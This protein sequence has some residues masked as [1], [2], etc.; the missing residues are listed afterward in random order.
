MILQNNAYVFQFNKI[1]S[2]IN[3]MSIRF[4]LLIV[5][6]KSILVFVVIMCLI[7]LIYPEKYFLILVIWK[8]SWIICCNI[9]VFFNFN[10]ILFKILL[11]IL[12]VLTKN[13][14]NQQLLFFLIIV[15]FVCF[16]N[17]YCVKIHECY[18]FLIC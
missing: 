11:I 2:S 4:K 6:I 18:C 10:L 8:I 3:T 13:R 17:F 5:N 15:F 14:M 7:F 1:Q 12:H 9:F 16:Q